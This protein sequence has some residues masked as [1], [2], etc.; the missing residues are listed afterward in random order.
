MIFEGRMDSLRLLFKC[1]EYSS[2]KLLQG[3]ADSVPAP[4]SV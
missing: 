3:S 2:R 4:P 1:L